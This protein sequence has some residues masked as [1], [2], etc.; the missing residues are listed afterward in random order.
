M[1]IIASAKSGKE[2]QPAPAGTHAAVCC[3]IVDLG[4]LEVTFGGKTKSQHKIRVVWQIDEERDDGKPFTVGKRYTLSLHEKSNLRKDLESWRGKSF[5]PEELDGF[6]LEVLI[7][8]GCMVNIIHQP[9]QDGGQPWAN[10]AAVMKLLKGMSAP[11]IREY[12]RVCDRKDEDNNQ[13][14][15]ESREYAITDDD[16]PF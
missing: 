6:D 12:V 13:S 11:I 14:I 3:D 10:V 2:F 16:V 7:G 1:S 4:T 5:T 15:S 9:K 8:I